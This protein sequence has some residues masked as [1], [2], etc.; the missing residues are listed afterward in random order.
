[1]KQQ[2][3]VFLQ[4]FALLISAFTSGCKK[5]TPKALPSITTTVVTNI[6]ANS[7][8]SGGH[9]S[10]DGGTEVLNRGLCCGTSLNSTL[11][12][13]KTN[14]GTGIGSFTSLVTGLL[15][16]TTYYL[17]AYAANSE[18]EAYGSVL[19]VTTA[20]VTPTITTTDV[21]NIGSS[22]VTSGGSISTDGGS[23]VTVRGV[24]W[25]PTQNP[26]TGNSKTTDGT[27][28]G[29]FTSKLTFLAPSTTF[30]LRAYATN[31]VGT[32][33][34]SQIRF[35]TLNSV[36]SNLDGV[37]DRGD[38]VITISGT[39]GTFTLINSGGWVKL[40]DAGVISIGSVKIQNI[41]QVTST[42]W[43]CQDLWC[44]NP[45]D[46]ILTMG[47]ST[48]GTIKMSPDGNSITVTSASPFSSSS[49]S[50]TCTRY[51]KKS[52]RIYQDI[53]RNN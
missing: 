45:D 46:I 51:G 11:A 27:G 49:S 1:M 13:S 52:M 53:L 32:S 36:N 14:D 41:S 3:F 15:P 12:N 23:A 16:G 4:V 5:E 20:A 30:Y 33:Y 35:T 48:S 28:T 50:Y 21:S 43:N 29:N 26:T 17:K 40:I 39:T 47:W 24:C 42:E 8:T 2:N 44:K 25:A 37:W 9:I 31:S 22:T 7:F 6:T 38:I 18:G 19:T 10:S 34:G